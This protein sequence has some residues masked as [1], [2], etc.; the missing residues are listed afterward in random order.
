[1]TDYRA[2]LNRRYWEFQ[3]SQ[4]PI[5]EEFFERPYADE[6]RPPVFLQHKEWLNAVF[7]PQASP[8]ERDRLL[9]LV[10]KPARHQWFRSMN[11]SQALAQSVLGNLA[12]HGYLDCLTELS[13]DEGESLLGEAKASSD[14][15]AMEFDVDH[16]GEPRPT[17]LDGYFF[18][19]YKV[20]IECKFTEAE[21]GTCSRP[22]INRTSS[23]YERDH[24]D[25]SYSRKGS[26]RER[27]PLGEVGV[28]YW[29]YIPSL[30]KWGSDLDLIPCPLHRNYQLVRN[31][32]AVG[33][34]AEGEVSSENGHVVLIYDGR[35]PAFQEKGDGLSAYWDTRD[36]LKEP[37]MLR[38]CS[39]QRIIQHIRQNGILPWLPEQ[40][41]LKYGM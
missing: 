14:N 27:C 8:I 4:F 37:G 25:G 1:M 15:F 30:F 36:A 35:N 11:S 22:R 39:W 16:L 21:V 31:I 20:A 23:K 9:A 2:D 38:R 28:L 29:R 12:V 18:E 34:N 32:L 24:C 10:P 40:L 17:S 5:W 3:K 26:R 19:G 41:A 13:C 6:G 33:V 7:D